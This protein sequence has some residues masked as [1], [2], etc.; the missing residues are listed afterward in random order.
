[1]RADRSGGPAAPDGEVDR[2]AVGRTLEA[3]RADGVRRLA[4]LTGHF[5][6]LVAASQDSNA[7][8]EHDPEGQTIAF[9]RSQLDASVVRARSSVAE[10]EAALARLADGTYG[11]C[12]ACGRPIAEGRLE[13][14][15]TARTCIACAARARP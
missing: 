5:R 10:I 6:E 8:D 2:D 12:E 1:V 15:P 9:E 4:G 7:D 14:L 3:A 11:R 13:A